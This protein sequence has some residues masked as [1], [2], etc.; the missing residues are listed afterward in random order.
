MAKKW[1]ELHAPAEIKFSIQH[2]VLKDISLSAAEK[3][4]LH[5]IAGILKMKDWEE[6]PLFE[7]FYEITKRNGI[8]PKQFFKVAYNV[9][10]KKD[11]GPK[12]APFILAI[13]KEKVISLFE[14][15]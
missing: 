4:V 15:V 10:I 12:L 2:E 5:E 13:G 14:T 3:T 6:K 11:Q 8:E 1:L 9:L 7:Q